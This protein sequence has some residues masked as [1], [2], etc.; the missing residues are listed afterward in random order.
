MIKCWYKLLNNSDDSASEATI[1]G[2]II[3][4]DVKE[5]VKQKPEKTKRQRTNK[6]SH[7]MKC[8]EEIEDKM[9]ENERYRPFEYSCYNCYKEIYKH[10]KD[11]YDRHLKKYKQGQNDDSVQKSKKK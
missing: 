1:I 5:E 7:C 3:E 9:S 10:N 8:D 6:V 2:G 11:K 4:E